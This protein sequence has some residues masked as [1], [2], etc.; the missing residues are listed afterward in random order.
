MRLEDVLAEANRYGR[1]KIVLEDPAL[2]SLQISGGFRPADTQKL[3][4]TLAAALDLTLSRA[5]DGDFVL[6]R[7]LSARVSIREIF[8][9]RGATEPRRRAS[10]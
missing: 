4:E 7:R 2:G 10:G 8:P 5:A 1:Y 3:A 9:V 6:S